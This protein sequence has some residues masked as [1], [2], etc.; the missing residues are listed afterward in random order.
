MMKIQF[1]H[2]DVIEFLRLYS[3][4]KEGVSERLQTLIELGCIDE[5]S[6]YNGVKEKYNKII[7]ENIFYPNLIK[8][9]FLEAK[10]KEITGNDIIIIDHQDES[11]DGVACIACGYI[12]FEDK[13][14]SFYE[15]CPVCGWQNDGKI[16]DEYSSCNHTT[17]NE[18]RKEIDFKNRVALGNEIYIKN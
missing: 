9:S 7:L 1:T 16:A 8:N 15:I 12:V 4:F 18:Y 3:L 14:D 17:L 13:E 10:I 5:E 2:S 6:S 11:I